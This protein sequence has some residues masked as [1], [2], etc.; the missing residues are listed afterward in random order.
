ML[1]GRVGAD[2]VTEGCGAM[3]VCCETAA[4]V[5]IAVQTSSVVFAGTA[6]A[7]VNTGTVT[8]HLL[9]VV[10]VS[11]VRNVDVLVMISTDVF[12]PLVC[13]VVEGGQSVT[14]V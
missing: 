12:P 6:D 1:V 7:G 2:L 10:M 9:Q 13:V 8:V 5:E 11:V 4:T 14:V 3:D